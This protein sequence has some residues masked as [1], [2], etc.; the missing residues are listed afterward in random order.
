MAMQKPPW[1]TLNAVDVNK[2]EIASKVPLGVVDELKT[3][4]GTPNLGG[5][6][7]TAG[8][9]VFIGA[10]IDGRFRDSMQR[11]E[12]NFGLLPLKQVRTPLL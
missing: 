4:T 3:T 8:G 7:V 2:G 6:I 5:S 10:T 9:V 12:S 1:G 11:P